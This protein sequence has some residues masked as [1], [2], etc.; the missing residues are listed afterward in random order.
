MLCNLCPR[1]CNVDRK[2]KYGCCNV[3]DTALV[4]RA[5]LHFWEEPCISGKEGSGTV[6]FSGCNLG[7]EFC[8]NL[9]ISR[10]QIGK[11]VTPDRLKT[12]Y[13]NLIE[14]GANNINLVTPTHFIEPILESLDK[15][16]PVPVVW[17]S[18]AYEK[19]EQLERLR[20]RVN[21]FL[22]DLKYSSNA[23]GKKYSKAEN[24]FDVAA[25][26][27]LKM[28]DLV[29]DYE[30]NDKGIMQKGLI[31]RHLILPTETENSLRVIDWVAKNFDGKKVMFSLMSQFTPNGKG[32]LNRRL[33]Q[34]EYDYVTDYNEAFGI[35]NGFV[36]ELSS[37]KEEYIPDFD[38]TGVENV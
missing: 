37:A 35:E 32:S 28:Y 29:G 4:S 9:K 8:Q 23:L 16:L 26:A 27:I 20:G 10:G 33:T 5:A 7:C 25:K 36:Q 14:Q 30:L 1:S 13:Q 17:N 6:F 12:I 24:Y 11:A 31:I 34:D 21:I 2:I 15:P 18:S 38:L 22:P 3:S 19:E